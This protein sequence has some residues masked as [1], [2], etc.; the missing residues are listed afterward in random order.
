[1]TTAWARPVEGALLV[2]VRV[3]PK[4]SADRIDGVHLAADGTERLAVRVR[5]V[6]DGGEANLA[7]A[8]LLAR[9]FSVPKR[10]VRVASGATSRLK[11]LRIEG[12]GLDVVSGVP[13][14]SASSA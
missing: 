8:A 4:A 1:V 6:P 2:D 9:H 5:A 3:T 11:T 12:V 14:P 13:A 7:V 10:S